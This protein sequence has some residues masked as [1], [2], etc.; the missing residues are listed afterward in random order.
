MLE[1]V[2]DASREYRC[3]ADPEAGTATLVG[4]KIVDDAQG[5][6]V[7][8]ATFALDA[9]R[10]VCDIE[11]TL[12]ADVHELPPESAPD[13]SLVVTRVSDEIST[14]L[15]QAPGRTVVLT[16]DWLVAEFGEVAGGSWYRLA[17]SPVHLRVRGGQLLGIAARLP[18]QDPGGAKESAW[19][20]QLEGGV[21][22][23]S[24]TS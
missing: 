11:M 4:S 15:A 14:V 6:S 21:D 16:D 8:P 5:Y 7:G 23:V 19:L 1:V 12:S 9:G 17:D 13:V 10:I 2:W 24:W 18:E 20:D 22:P 3:F